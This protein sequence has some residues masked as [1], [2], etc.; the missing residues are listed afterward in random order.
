MTFY[1]DNK[2]MFYVQ[3]FMYSF[4]E[5]AANDCSILLIVHENQNIS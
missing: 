3:I 5:K 2:I 1:M 4:N